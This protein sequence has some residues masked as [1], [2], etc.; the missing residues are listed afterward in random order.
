MIRFDELRQDLRRRRSPSHDVSLDGRQPEKSS[1]LLRC[2]TRSRKTTSLKAASRSHPCQHS[3][4]IL[5]NS[6]PATP[7]RARPLGSGSSSAEKVYR[8]QRA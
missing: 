8:T 1:Q 7:T 6:R 3:G 4:Q 5:V 2:P